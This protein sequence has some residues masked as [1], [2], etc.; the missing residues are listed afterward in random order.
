MNSLRPLVLRNFQSEI[1]IPV[2]H[3]CRVL[4]PTGFKMAT[5]W[6]GPRDRHYPQPVWRRFYTSGR[7][8]ERN[9]RGLDAIRHLLRDETL[10]FEGGLQAIADIFTRVQRILKFLGVP[11]HRREGYLSRCTVA[12]HNGHL[13][14]V[15]RNEISVASAPEEIQRLIESSRGELAF[16]PVY[17][18]CKWHQDI[19]G[20][21]EDPDRWLKRRF[22]SKPT[23]V[24]DPI[25]GCGIHVQPRVFAPDPIVVDLAVAAFLSPRS[26]L[27]RDLEEANV[28]EPCTG[29]GILA[30]MLAAL[31]AKRVDSTEIDGR[32]RTCARLNIENWGLSDRLVVHVETWV[33]R[34]GSVCSMTFVNPPWYGSLD[35]L[36]DSAHIRRCVLDNDHKL[37]RR[38]L[39]ASGECF[40]KGVPFYV[41]LG[42]DHPFGDEGEGGPTQLIDLEKEGWKITH[43][44][45]SNQQVRLYR[46]VKQ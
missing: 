46:L 30:G 21:L 15:S 40:S 3:A 29:T 43:E 42:R 32:S 6:V 34:P 44:W 14:N 13:Q 24:F 33:P 28:F 23:D 22:F 2:L 11:R 20:I 35:N 19:P 8:G 27:A 17:L 12:L 4:A 39:Q 38:L 16:V 9:D 7:F 37:L 10:Y 41:F 5:V 26:P 18:V 36:A 31:G 45:D 25:L 1:Q